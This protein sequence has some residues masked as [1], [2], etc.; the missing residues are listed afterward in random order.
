[1]SSRDTSL[2]SR[3]ARRLSY[4]KCL[5]LALSAKPAKRSTTTAGRVADRKR[6]RT[7]VGV[8]HDWLKGVRKSDRRQTALA[9]VSAAAPVSSIDATLAR[10][11][12]SMNY[13]ADMMGHIDY[14][15]MHAPSIDYPPV[16]ADIVWPVHV[17]TIESGTKKLPDLHRLSLGNLMRILR[18]R[19]NVSLDTMAAKIGVTSMCISNAERGRNAPKLKTVAAIVN[20]LH[21][22]GK[23]FNLLCAR[24]AQV[25]PAWKWN[26]EASAE[27]ASDRKDSMRLCYLRNKAEKLR[28][29]GKI[30]D[31]TEEYV[32]KNFA[33]LKKGGKPDTKK[34]EKI[35]LPDVD[36]ES[37]VFEPKIAGH[38]A[39]VREGQD[40]KRKN[41]KHQH[42]KEE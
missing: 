25:L 33:R 1:M 22:N 24:L 11:K 37:D 14:E 36:A 29:A 32:M 21:L 2:T 3:N 15:I 5:R 16:A 17:I 26:A 28:K 18:E 41:R 12:E 38:P 23:E 7:F 6:A 34:I 35:E 4:S 30:S 8:N 27:H 20:E 31:D 9:E 13:M 39:Y 10:M 19:E 40:G 42:Q